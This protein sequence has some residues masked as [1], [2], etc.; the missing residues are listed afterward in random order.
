MAPRRPSTAGF[1]VSRDTTAITSSAAGT[2]PITPAA[3]GTHLSNYTVVANPGTLTVTQA[4]PVINW[5]NP[6]SIVYGTRWRLG[7][8]NLIA[9]TS[10]DQH[11][12]TSMPDRRPRSQSVRGR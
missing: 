9:R 3:S 6:A 4:T 2:Y 8:E 7:N 12:Y 1:E 10:G 5:N 11:S